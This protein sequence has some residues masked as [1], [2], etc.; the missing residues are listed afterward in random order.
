MLDRVQNWLKTCP[1]Y[2]GH[3]SVDYLDAAAPGMALYPQGAQQVS[4]VTDILGNCKEKI[5]Y[6]FLVKVVTGT[7]NREDATRWALDFQQ[8]VRL[9]DAQKQAP[10]LG[11]NTQWHAQKGRLES[12]TKTGTCIYCVELVSE[13]EIEG[14]MQ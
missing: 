13:F 7:K 11:E 10:Q 3:I 1:G 4:R 12:V 14:E 9:Q 5:R 6:R 8:W 2:P